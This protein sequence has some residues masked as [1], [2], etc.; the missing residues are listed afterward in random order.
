LTRSPVL[1]DHPR[2]RIVIRAVADQVDDALAEAALGPCC[3][4][5]VDDRL[6]ECRP[7]GANAPVEPVDR[8]EF[9]FDLVAQANDP[10]GHHWH[11]V[12][13]P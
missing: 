4:R 13:G 3:H 11:L 2:D 7:T 9:P 8:G 5:R 12:L 6:I 1:E 10:V